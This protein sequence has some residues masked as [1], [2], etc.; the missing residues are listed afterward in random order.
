M[1]SNRVALGRIAE[2]D[3]ALKLDK[4]KIA[5]EARLD[6][7]YLIRTSGEHLSAENV[8]RGYK[9]LH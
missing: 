4:A 9:H 6:G 8:V 2:A 1:R 5:L 3:A 7:K